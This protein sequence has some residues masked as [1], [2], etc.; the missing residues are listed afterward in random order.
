M[1]LM[2]CASQKPKIRRYELTF[3]KVDHFVV[4][5]FEVGVLEF[6]PYILPGGY[7]P[8]YHFPVYLEGEKEGNFYVN[9][10]GSPEELNPFK[11]KKVSKK[12]LYQQQLLWVLEEKTQENPHKIL[13]RYDGAPDY[14]QIKKD[15]IAILSTRR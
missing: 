1:V 8:L 6:E 3:K 13:K 15:V 2:A 9:V 14:S 10:Y 12:F 7:I 4:E 5:R 11:F